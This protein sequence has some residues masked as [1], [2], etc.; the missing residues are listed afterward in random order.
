[1]EE[2]AKPEE[3]V[4]K[5]RKKKVKKTPLSVV[6]QTWAFNKDEMENATQQL[7]DLGMKDKLI[8]DTLDRKNAVESYVYETRDAVDMNLREFISD[9]DRSAFV[10]L[11]NA[12]ED[13]LYGD[14]EYGTKSDY[15]KKLEELKVYGD[16]VY[17]R[18]KEA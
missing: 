3:K 12:T 16:P 5:K 15:V 2:E 17:L 7:L 8:A 4:E 10:E 11:L 13:W 9:D 14:G 18:S 1:M 6:G